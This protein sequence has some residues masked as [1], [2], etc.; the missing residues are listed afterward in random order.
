MASMK[1][2]HLLGKLCDAMNLITFIV[3]E[4]QDS[5]SQLDTLDNNRIER[6]VPS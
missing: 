5:R 4:I 2:I 6:N 3:F 1:Y